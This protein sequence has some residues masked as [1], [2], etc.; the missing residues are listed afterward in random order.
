MKAINF[1]TDEVMDVVPFGAFSPDF[2]RLYLMDAN[3]G[4]P[5]AWL[6]TADASHRGAWHVLPGEPEWAGETIGE[7]YN[8]D[9]GEWEEEMNTALENYG[10]RLGDEDRRLGGYWLEEL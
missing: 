4:Y 6:Y 1:D 3:T 5:M 7:V 2:S 9:E 10:F 8:E